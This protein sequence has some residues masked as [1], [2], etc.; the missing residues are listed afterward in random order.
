MR[1]LSLIAA[2]PHSLV[3]SNGMDAPADNRVAVPE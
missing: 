1:P 3:V 2:L